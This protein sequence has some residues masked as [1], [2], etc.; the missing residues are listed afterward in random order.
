[1]DLTP[2]R[3]RF[4]L[5]LGGLGIGLLAAPLAWR[6]SAGDGGGAPAPRERSLAEADLYGPHGLAG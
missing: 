4:L 3:R 2:P 5:W 1:M 6:V